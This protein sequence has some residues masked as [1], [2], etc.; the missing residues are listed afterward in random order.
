M[1]EELQQ[2]LNKPMNELYFHWNDSRDCD[3][4]FTCCPT[5]QPCT[6]SILDSFYLLAT[7]GRSE[8]FCRIWRDKLSSLIS[9]HEYAF[10]QENIVDFV[11]NP[12][13]EYCQ[14]LIT[15]LKS[16]MI[17]LSEIERVFCGD[18]TLTDVQV[19]C[20]S[21]FKSLTSCY[22]K[23]STFKFCTCK[24]C[25]TQEIKQY[26]VKDSS[27]FIYGSK[28]IETVFKQIEHHRLC[29]KCK[30]CAQ[31]VLTLCDEDHLNLTGDFNSLHVLI[32]KV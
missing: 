7:T 30:E 9:Q 1:K 31:T 5:I 32:E 16:G 29:L 10:T 20:E 13:F 26:L 14:L 12:T 18:K 8:V 4:G 17:P 11:W 25:T 27:M 15:R 23:H 2:V 28:W 6:L 3:L 21:L 22:Y 24:C 19:S